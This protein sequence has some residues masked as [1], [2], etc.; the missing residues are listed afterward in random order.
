MIL[1]A[2]EAPVARAVLSIL[3]GIA[4]ATAPLVCC[5]ACGCLRRQAEVCPVCQ[6]QA[7]P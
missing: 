2:D 4:T 3:L 6:P 1:D 7:W 5:P